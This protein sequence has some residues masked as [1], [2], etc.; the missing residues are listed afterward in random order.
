MAFGSTAQAA[1]IAA[2]SVLNIVGNA[3]FTSTDVTFTNPANLV[4]DSGNFA[5]LG[6]CTGCVTMTTPLQSARPPSAGLHGDEP[7]AYN[8]LHRQHPGNP[9]G[10]RPHYARSDLHWHR[11]PDRLRPDAGQVDADGQP[12]RQSDGSC[13]R[14]DD[15]GRWPRKGAVI[16]AATGAQSGYFR[17]LTVTTA[18]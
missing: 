2:G 1:Q 14:S 8:H 4:L 12:V 7:W 9:L 3:N 5:A 15:R 11:D 18:Q 16:F 10:H 13:C 6:T 17:S